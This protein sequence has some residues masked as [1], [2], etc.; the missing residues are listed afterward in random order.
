MVTLMI[1]YPPTAGARFFTDIA[2]QP[3]LARES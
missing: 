1:S 3:M 2:P